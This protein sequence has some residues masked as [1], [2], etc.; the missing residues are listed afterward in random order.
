MYCSDTEFDDSE[1][2]LPSITEN[3]EILKPI[4]RSK[5]EAILKFNLPSHIADMENADDDESKAA[6]LRTLNFYANKRKKSLDEAGSKKKMFLAR[7]VSK[8]IHKAHDKHLESASFV[9]ENRRPSIEITQLEEEKNF[10]NRK[11]QKMYN[12]DG[13]SDFDGRT[14]FERTDFEGTKCGGSCHH[15]TELSIL[16]HEMSKLNDKFE[17]L[18]SSIIFQADKIENLEKQLKFRNEDVFIDDI[19]D[20]EGICPPL[21]IITKI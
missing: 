11:I 5:S 6:Y 10:G 16:T 1:E 4:S 12:L 8:L 15:D 17:D 3:T 9:I 14:D 7:K 20:T 21:P 18:Q 19:D 2:R 13:S